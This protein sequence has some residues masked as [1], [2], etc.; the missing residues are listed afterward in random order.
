MLTPS[1]IHRLIANYYTADFETPIAPEIL[2]EVSARIIPG[3]KTDHLLLP[4]D[5]EV[6]P[7]EVPLPRTIAG[8]ETFLPVRDRFQLARTYLHRRAELRQC[9]IVEALDT[10]MHLSAGAFRIIVSISRRCNLMCIIGHCGG[11]EAA[12]QI[13]LA[14]DPMPF[15]R[16][17]QSKAVVSIGLRGMSLREWP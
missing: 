17:S 12:F 14:I 10:A 16:P 6:G 5:D 15:S 3:D 13:C 1:Q 7:Y 9:T 2:K 4:P 11:Y 8:L